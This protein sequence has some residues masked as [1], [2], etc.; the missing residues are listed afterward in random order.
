MSDFD[1]DAEDPRGQSKGSRRNRFSSDNQPRRRR[2]REPRKNLRASM[3]AQMRQ[4][5]KITIG[6][7]V[8][9]VEYIE[10]LLQSLS[11]DLLSAKVADK[12]RYLEK[13]DKLG[14]TSRLA[15]QA[16][17]DDE[18]AELEQ[19]R[20]EFAQLERDWQHV[21]EGQ[22]SIASQQKLQWYAAARIL[23]KVRQACECS[24]FSGKFAQDTETLCH[25][26]VQ[27][28]AN[29]CLSEEMLIYLRQAMTETL[30]ESDDEGEL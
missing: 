4:P 18:R 13:L 26:F 22:N 11:K 17:L 19:D 12:L 3:L 9:T 23:T 10:A 6:G 5:V 8:K 25:T 28:E 16:K 24:A 21:R 14:L 27:D 15:D 29:D 7:I 20:R 2:Q 1:S 30:E